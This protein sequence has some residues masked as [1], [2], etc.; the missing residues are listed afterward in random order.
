[1]FSNDSTLSGPSVQTITV[2]DAAW[3]D[4]QVV[5]CRLQ[6]GMYMWVTKS[7]L[8]STMTT[9]VMAQ[10]EALFVLQEAS[11]CVYFQVGVS[12][13]LWKWSTALT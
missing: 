2:C 13:H 8:D 6:C 10:A 1:M 7:A 9:S 5:I 3:E 11:A 4:D 12:A